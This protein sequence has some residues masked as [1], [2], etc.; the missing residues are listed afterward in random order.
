M[1]Y[2]RVEKQMDHKQI[3]SSLNKLELNNYSEYMKIFRK[4]A[5]KHD[6]CYQECAGNTLSAHMVE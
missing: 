1:T 3:T 6:T 4:L 2:F 5:V